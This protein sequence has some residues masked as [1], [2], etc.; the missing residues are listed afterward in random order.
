MPARLTFAADLAE[1]AR[2]AP[3][4]ASLA[5]TSA[6]PAKLAFAIE[7]C[8]DEVVTNIALH[9]GAAA[10][11]ISI[12]IDQDAGSVT[13]RIEDVGAAFDPTTGARA[14]PTSLD[15]A[16]IGGLGLVLVQHYASELRYERV[17]ERNRLTLRFALG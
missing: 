7:L 4:L 12:E 1:T 6:W 15:E 8:L 16:E 3:W 13:A 5:E 2:L 9:G 17:D 14:V 11:K 10:G